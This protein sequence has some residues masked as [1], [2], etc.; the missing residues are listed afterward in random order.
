[1]PFPGY[2]HDRSGAGGGLQQDLDRDGS[3]GGEALLG[4][5]DVGEG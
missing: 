4:A 5:W 3:E 2:V 1:M